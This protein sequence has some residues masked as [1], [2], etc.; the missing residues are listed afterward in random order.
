MTEKKVGLNR[1]RLDDVC[2]SRGILP[3]WESVFV[4][5][6]RLDLG[7][8]GSRKETTPAAHTRC[9]VAWAP[10]LPWLLPYEAARRLHAD[11]TAVAVASV[12]CPPCVSPS[13]AFSVLPAVPDDR[14]PA[15]LTR[16]LGTLRVGRLSRPQG[17]KKR[18]LSSMEHRFEPTESRLQRRDVPSVGFSS[19]FQ[20]RSNLRAHPTTQVKRKREDNTAGVQ[21]KR[22]DARQPRTSWDTCAGEG[23]RHKPA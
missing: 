4:N 21:T 17:R 13:W 14:E 23:C 7:G 11:T 18:Q 1:A 22:W 5:I 20:E 10:N 2:P 9:R 6:L 19:Y 12:E 8:S 16:T 15:F 3:V